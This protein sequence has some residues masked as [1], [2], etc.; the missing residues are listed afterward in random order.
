MSWFLKFQVKNSYYKNHN[1]RIV[2]ST[3][4]EISIFVE[5]SRGSMHHQINLMV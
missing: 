2:H 1:I 3:F 4:D 5:S